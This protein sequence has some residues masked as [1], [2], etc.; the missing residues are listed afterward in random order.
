MMMMTESLVLV[1][2]AVT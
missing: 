1:T 2:Y